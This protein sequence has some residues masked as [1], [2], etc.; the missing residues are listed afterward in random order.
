FAGLALPVAMDS[1]R[2]VAAV[3]FAA[4]RLADFRPA[5]LEVLSALTGMAG[6][7]SVDVCRPD[8]Y[9]TNA[10]GQHKKGLQSSAAS[11]DCDPVAPN[12][13]NAHRRPSI[14]FWNA[15]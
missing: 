5:S 10:L 4:L 9:S 15:S 13:V 6:T 8:R 7:C 2:V 14:F 3:P 11:Q 12:P 1:G